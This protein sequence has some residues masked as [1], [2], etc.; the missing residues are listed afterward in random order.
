MSSAVLLALAMQLVDSTARDSAAVRRV[1]AAALQADSATVATARIRFTADTAWVR[2]S[3]PVSWAAVRVERRDG[4]WVSTGPIARG[5][6]STPGGHSGD[7]TNQGASYN[8]W[9][10]LT[11][12]DE[13]TDSTR[14]SVWRASLPWS[15]PAML[16]VFC[17]PEPAVVIMPKDQTTRDIN[18]DRS[19]VR[20]RIDSAPV[21]SSGVWRTGTDGS[22]TI[23]ITFGA[24]F[25]AQLFAADSLRVEYPTGGASAFVVSRFA[26]GGLRKKLTAVDPECAGVTWPR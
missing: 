4:Q 26:V 3:G 10:I 1:A 22:A 18:G 17:T 8:E 23:L 21:V 25:I 14:N 15:A 6:R 12:R 13:L 9:T 20:T 11:N 2:V 7:S 24:K 16:G 19:P 5:I